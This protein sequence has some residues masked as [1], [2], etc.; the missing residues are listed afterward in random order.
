MSQNHGYPPVTDTLAIENP[1]ISNNRR[2]SD[3]L[4]PRPGAK[5]DK[6]NTTPPLNW[7]LSDFDVGNKLG[8]GKFGRVYLARLKMADDKGRKTILA[9][10]SILKEDIKRERLK[11]QLIREIEIQRK[12]NNFN[13][14]KMFGYFYDE[15]RVYILLEYAP[16]GMLYR[17][18]KVAGRLTNILVATYAYQVVQA[19]KYLHSL[20]IIHRDIKPENCLLGM[21]GELKLCDFGWAVYAPSSRRTTMCGTLDYLP[22]EML[23]EEPKHDHAVDL[24]ALGV[25]TYELL[26]GGPPFEHEDGRKTQRKIRYLDYTFPA[27]LKLHYASKDF[28]DGLLKLDPS[29]RLLLTD[30]ENHH[31]LDQF[32]RPHKIDPTTN[33]YEK[34]KEF[35]D[36]FQPYSQRESEQKKFREKSQPKSDSCNSNN[37][38]V[39]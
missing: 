8:S 26:V 39:E 9:I 24:W 12:L 4:S 10:K 1:I 29:K 21:M 7:K 37:K 19:L 35:W 14:L 25:L 33:W 17:V 30:L 2:E 18:L 38:M 27:A 3:P 22:P 5:G 28:I 20:D 36:H 13:I 11:Y 34:N 6:V 16:E 15:K 23:A 32:A 31:Y